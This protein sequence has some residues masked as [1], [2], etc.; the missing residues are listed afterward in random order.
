MCHNC[1]SKAVAAASWYMH[2]ALQ[3][4]D[5]LVMS[6][7]HLEN[8]RAQH[9]QQSKIALSGRLWQL[10]ALAAQ[11]MS[12]C[13]IA[14]NSNRLCICAQAVAASTYP[15]TSPV[16][17]AA[18]ASPNS[19][20]SQGTSLVLPSLLSPSGQQFP[21]PQIRL[22]FPACRPHQVSKSL[23]LRVASQRTAT[24]SMQSAA[25]HGSS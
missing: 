7:T 9:V 21:S 18:P 22:Y 20:P 16:P 23:L 6:A 10:Q 15:P 24:H 1:V 3:G 17:T 13:T 4:N 5:S 19:S 2:I 14:S 8:F 12:E 25:A 11:A